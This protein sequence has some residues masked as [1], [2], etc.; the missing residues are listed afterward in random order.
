MFESKETKP[1]TLCLLM[2]VLVF[3]HHGNIFF[4]LLCVQGCLLH[5]GGRHV[6]LCHFLVFAGLLVSVPAPYLFLVIWSPQV[7]PLERSLCTNCLFFFSR[8]NFQ[9]GVTDWRFEPFLKCVYHNR[10]MLVTKMF[11][12]MCT[13]QT[14]GFWALPSCNFCAPFRA[15]WAWPPCNFCAPY[16]AL[17][18]WPP[19]NFCVPY[20][21]HWA[22]PPC[23]FCAPNRAHWA[24]PPCN[25]CAPYRALWARPP[26]NFCAPN[27][28]LWAWPPCNFCAPNRAL[29]AWPP[30]NFC[31]PYCALWAWCPRP[32]ALLF[33]VACWPQRCSH[34]VY[35]QDSQRRCCP[36]KVWLF[37]SGFERTRV[38]FFC[39]Q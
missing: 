2:V 5:F 27:R 1:F 10:K 14:H 39:W 23:N 33:P 35:S 36:V 19:C 17:W 18:A 12:S 30:C 9:T 24:W 6:V 11:L 31:A 3:S 28:A 37:H 25:F 20:R 34:T 8:D 21:A 29:W 38:H 32:C 15:L 26:C 16:R 7:M 4:A 13:A 22:W